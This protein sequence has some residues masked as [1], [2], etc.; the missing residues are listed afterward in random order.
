MVGKQKLSKS[1][2]SLTLELDELFD[3]DFTGH[4][5]LRAE[6]AESILDTIVERTVDDGRGVNGRKFKIYDKDYAIEK[7][8]PR[9][10][11]DLYLSGDMM[12]TIEDRSDSV[13]TLKLQVKEGVDTLKALNH[14]TKKDSVNKLPKRE[15]MGIQKKEI[16]RIKREYRSEFEAATEPE[17]EEEEQTADQFLEQATDAQLFEALFG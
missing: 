3:F 7:G 4:E 13:N 16:N 1:E 5:A 14:N 15:F 6:I 10:A 2:V 11:V 12:E 17:V 9:S 8:V